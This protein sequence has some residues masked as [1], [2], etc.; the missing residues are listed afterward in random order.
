MNQ[1]DHLNQA[2]SHLVL[3]GGTPGCSNSPSLSHVGGNSGSSSVGNTMVTPGT[4]STGTNTPTGGDQET[5]GNKKSVGLFKKLKEKRAKKRSIVGQENAD[6]AW[7]TGSPIGEERKSIINR[8]YVPKSTEKQ[9][10]IENQQE[11]PFNAKSPDSVDST[12]QRSWSHGNINKISQTDSFD[13]KMP[14]DQ[15]VSHSNS[16]SFSSSTGGG[17]GIQ[18]SPN[19][20]VSSDKYVINGPSSGDTKQQEKSRPKIEGIYITFGDE[21]HKQTLKDLRDYLDSSGEVEPLDLSIIQDWNGWVIGTS[22][23]V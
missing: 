18:P 1:N 4:G 15:S 7:R 20:S 19:S 21:V 3:L 22:D 11:K 9:S 10:S 5:S 17:G 8:K 6:G 13:F 2:L 12:R 16:L 23:I 14:N